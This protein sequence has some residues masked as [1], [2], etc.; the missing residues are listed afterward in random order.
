M[1]HR[2]VYV[3]G[4]GRLE[5][6]DF[7]T[8]YAPSMRA[9]VSPE[10]SWIVGDFRGVDMLAMEFLK[11][12]SERVTV[13]HVGERPRYL[14]DRH[15]TLAD[16]WTLLGGFADDRSRDEAAIQRCTHYL[17]VDRWAT[18]A[19]PTGTSSLIARC[20]ELGKVSLRA[21]PREEAL[22][23]LLARID[24]SD[25]HTTAQSFA[26]ELLALFPSWFD[27]APTSVALLS[28][29]MGL[30]LVVSGPSPH[31][32]AD[33]MLLT[34]SDSRGMSCAVTSSSGPFATARIDMHYRPT[35]EQRARARAVIALGLRAL[36][37][38]RPID[39]SLT[40]L[41]KGREVFPAGW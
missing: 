7:L 3:F 23:A 39:P 28:W 31:W 13:V 11:T 33:V 34:T 15:G 6:D 37:P 9:A 41:V 24:A 32:G 19:R 5:L 14:P 4:N 35:E 22:A 25:A 27:F 36:F 38:E 17:A 30:H 12:R 10:T 26:R 21:S 40:A 1:S 29:S 16:A 8:L 18:P 20:D 2:T